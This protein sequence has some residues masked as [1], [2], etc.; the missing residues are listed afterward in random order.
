M[1]LTSTYTTS[2]VTQ[3]T[4]GQGGTYQGAPITTSTSNAS[5]PGGGPVPQVL[6]TGANTIAIPTGY[7][8]VQIIP[9]SANGAALTAKG[10]TG[11]TGISL[12]LTTPTTLTFAAGQSNFCLTAASGVTV[13]LVWF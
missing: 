4:L 11:D 7:I 13:D 8:G 6:S 2:I 3:G 5:P 1:S 12:H 9:P 10:V